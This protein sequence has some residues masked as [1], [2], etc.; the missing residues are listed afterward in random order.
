MN[1]ALSCVYLFIMISSLIIFDF[2][3]DSNLSNWNVV[4]DGV[5]GGISQ[6][7]FEINKEG[8]AV[9]K[10]NVS[11]ENNGGFSS[12]RYRFNSKKV[13]EFT[14]VLIR[15]KGDQKKYQ[16]RIKT[17]SSDRYSY[18][19]HFKTTGDWQTVEVSLSEMYPAFRGRKLDLPNYPIETMQEIA[20]LI[21][22]KKAEQF[23]LEIDKIELK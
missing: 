15:L 21:G 3:K 22:N 4:D 23:R 2:T 20:F 14:K 13:K 11:L 7:K 18:I 6:G 8:N 10:G 12:V 19:A 16:F 9:F 5:M 17:N 1:T